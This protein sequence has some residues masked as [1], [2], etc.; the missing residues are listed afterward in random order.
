MGK[1]S[2]D[3][4]GL[5]LFILIS[6]V[7]DGASPAAVLQSFL[8]AYL[9]VSQIW[10]SC[11]LV[12]AA[13]KIFYSYISLTDGL[14]LGRSSQN[15]ICRSAQNLRKHFCPAHLISNHWSFSAFHR[16]SIAEPGVSPSTILR[17]IKQPSARPSIPFR[18]SKLR[19][20]RK[21]MNHNAFR[22]P[23]RPG[24]SYHPRRAPATAWKPFTAPYLRPYRRLKTTFPA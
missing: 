9:N 7:S 17:L 23:S 16:L 1:L 21:K 11:R 14:A 24:I 20:K 19:K 10:V 22:R 6:F 15:N 5:L 12:T 2:P 18:K 8:C 13:S 3:Y 4:G